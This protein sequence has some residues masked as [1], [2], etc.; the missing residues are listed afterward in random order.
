MKAKILIATVLLLMTFSIASALGLPENIQKINEY[1]KEY[2][3]N[4]LLKITIPIAFIAGLISFIAPCTLALFP[5]FFSYAFKEKKEIT[6]MSLVFFFGFAL[7][8]VAM[9]L[10]AGLIGQTATNLIP[11]KGAFILIAGLFLIFLGA[12]SIFGKGIASFIKIRK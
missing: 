12:L 5:A 11:N 4:F 3:S 6:K 2:S 8:F 1:N 9:G 10:I 7:T